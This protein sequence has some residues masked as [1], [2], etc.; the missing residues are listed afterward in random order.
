MK[1][2]P[3]YLLVP[4]SAHY[5]PG[6]ALATLDGYE[7]HPAPHEPHGSF[8]IYLPGP[9]LSLVWDEAPPVFQTIETLTLEA[10]PWHHRIHHLP[11]ERR[12][13]ARAGKPRRQAVRVPVAVREEACLFTPRGVD[14]G[15]VGR[16]ARRLLAVTA[17]VWERP[18]GVKRRAPI[19]WDLETTPPPRRLTRAQKAWMRTRW[20][21]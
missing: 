20:P 4:S 21:A 6:G 16:A 13:M 11:A 3:R 7:V 2:P 12:A 18:P 19:N 15:V 8:R 10:S 14:A 1:D 17:T 5:R 9:P